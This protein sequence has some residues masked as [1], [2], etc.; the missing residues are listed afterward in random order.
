MLRRALILGFACAVKAA[1]AT[2]LA[3]EARHERSLAATCASCH[4]RSGSAYSLV[5]PLEG[6][7]EATIAGALRQFKSGTRQGT[8]M[9]QL[10][11][12]YTDEQIEAIARWYARAR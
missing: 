7:S 3:P 8:V 10:A 12:G 5:S 1:F 4:V 2:E 6:R 11:K 9:P